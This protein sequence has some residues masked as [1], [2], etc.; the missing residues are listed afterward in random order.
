MPQALAATPTGTAAATGTFSK[1][2]EM[3]TFT[4]PVWLPLL[5]PVPAAPVESARAT[6]VAVGLLVAV[7]ACASS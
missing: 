6:E 1:M 5:L 4:N 7:Q 2:F 3:L